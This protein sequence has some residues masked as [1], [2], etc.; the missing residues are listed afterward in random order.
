MLV[1]RVSI[2]EILGAYGQL[3][4]SLGYRGAKNGPPKTVKN[5]QNGSKKEQIENESKM[6]SFF[7]CWLSLQVNWRF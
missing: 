4:R 1:I 2:L 6:S 5:H 7:V 3:W